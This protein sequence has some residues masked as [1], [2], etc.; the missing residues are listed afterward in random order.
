[1]KKLPKTLIALGAASAVALA[2]CSS[3]EVSDNVSDATSSVSD[4]ASDA[5][6]AVSDQADKA[7]AALKD[8]DGSYRSLG[9]YINDPEMAA[10]FAKAAL[11]HSQNWEDLKTKILGT[12]GDGKEGLVIDGDQMTFVGDYKDLDNPADAPSTY[13]FEETVDRKVGDDDDYTWYV[14]KAADDSAP[15]PFL[16]LGEKE[17][18]DNTTYFHARFG[19]NKDELLDTQELPTFVDPDTATQATIEE[20]LFD[21]D[22]EHADGHDHEGHDHDDHDHD[23]D[24]DH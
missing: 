21:H 8:W 5:S 10:D 22:H 9:S 6:D 13:E 17:D 11:D 12:Y 4:A 15:Y 18:E 1:M 2:G 19:D 20:L 3:D 16:I 24:H 7:A 23:H 14:F